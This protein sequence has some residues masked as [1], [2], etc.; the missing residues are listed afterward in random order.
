MAF[1]LDSCV[2]I[3][4]CDKRDKHYHD[5]QDFFRKYPIGKY[6]HFTS[7]IIE[8]N[9]RTWRRRRAQDGI[10]DEVIELIMSCIKMLLRKIIK[11]D[12]QGPMGI[13][14]Y[15]YLVDSFTPIVGGNET[16]AFFIVDAICWNIFENISAPTFVTSDYKDIINMKERIIEEAKLYLPKYEDKITLQIKSIKECNA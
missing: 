9:L 13:V 7:P 12:Y 6:E 3:G 14:Q 16:D 10:E 2:I 1:F 15:R 11:R 5:C 4:Y 8:R